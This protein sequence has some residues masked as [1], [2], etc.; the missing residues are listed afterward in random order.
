MHRQFYIQRNVV[1]QAQTAIIALLVACAFMV[2]C[3]QANTVK[4]MVSLD[5]KTAP[6]M[7]AEDVSA[8]ISD[9]GVTRARLTADVWD[10]L[11][12]KDGTVWYFPEGIFVEQFDSTFQV[13][14]TIVA[15]TAYNF[16][17]T[18]IWRL[19]KN[20]RIVNLA[21]TEFTSSEFYWDE[22]KQIVYSDSI[23]C[24][25]EHGDES[26]I[27]SRGFWSRQDMTKYTLYKPFDSSFIV[28]ENEPDILNDTTHIYER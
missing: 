16:I 21:Q 15:D 13:V 14:A 5:E 23:V 2:S 20:V 22:K 9:S 18:S 19:I 11:S 10:V 25:K 8:L 27:Y 24:I 3:S 17:R 26:V 28:D 6:L 1:S 12:T 4:E 7:H